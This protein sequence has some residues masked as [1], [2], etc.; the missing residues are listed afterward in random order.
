MKQIREGRRKAGRVKLQVW[1]KVWILG[2]I[3]A[4]TTNSDADRTALAPAKS[5]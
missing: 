3:A 4:G 1:M 2:V 5:S